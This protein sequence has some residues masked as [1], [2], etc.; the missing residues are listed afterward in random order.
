MR[1]RLNCAFLTRSMVT[2]ANPCLDKAFQQGFKSNSAL[3]G[4]VNAMLDLRGDARITS[5][6]HNNI[7]LPSS[8]ASDSST[9]YVFTVSVRCKT[10]NGELILV[11]LQ[12]DYSADYYL[13]ALME[14][15]RVLGNMDI[16]HASKQN[17]EP[18]RNIAG[19]YTIV[20]TDKRLTRQSKKHF[21]KEPVKEPELVNIYELRH[22]T[23]LQRHFGD[24]PNVLA[25][26]MLSNLPEK[27]VGQMSA[28]ERWASVFYDASTC[29]R[30]EKVSLWKEIDAEELKKADSQANTGIAEFIDRMDNTKMSD[31]ERRYLERDYENYAAAAS[32]FEE[33]VTANIVR[34]FSSNCPLFSAAEI[35]AQLGVPIEI[36]Q[37]A[38]GQTPFD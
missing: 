32:G 23:H 34:Q 4:F 6:E 36:V 10:A 31:E 13:K 7:N 11:E 38:L 25:L 12:N 37:E 3:A 27:P 1:I 30:N 21:C 17:H 24:I 35:S 16:I 14:H 33:R 9:R 28:A 15:S 20:I 26:V 18:L 19:V 5:V 2:I 29:G 8:G 22:T